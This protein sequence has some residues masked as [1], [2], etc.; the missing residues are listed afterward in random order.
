MKIVK[1]LRYTRRGCRQ[2]S[3]VAPRQVSSATTSFKKWMPTTPLANDEPDP[4]RNNGGVSLIVAMLH[5]VNVES[6]KGNHG[7]TFPRER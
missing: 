5:D 1:P 3:G 4:A 2:A 6:V 7:T